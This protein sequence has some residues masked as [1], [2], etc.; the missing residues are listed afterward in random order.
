[1]SD[2]PTQHTAEPSDVH[3]TVESPSTASEAT[4]TGAA[5]SEPAA[6]QKVAEKPAENAP[7]E[8]TLAG[9]KLEDLPQISGTDPNIERF[10]ELSYTSP[11]SA[12]VASQ[13]LIDNFD[14][15]GLW[16]ASLVQPAHLAAELRQECSELSSLVIMQWVRQGE[17]HKL[18]VLSETLLAEPP[19][20]RTR[21]TARIMTVLA[22]LLGILRPTIA[23]RLMNTAT[24]YLSDLADG[25]LLRDARQ[26]VEAGRILERCQPEERVFWNRHL[27]EPGN[28]WDWDS[29][30]ARL[31]L[32]HL[33]GILPEDGGELQVFQAAVPGCW[34]DL[35]R[36]PR[37]ANDGKPPALMAPAA[38]QRKA[39]GFGPGLLLG[40]AAA[41]AIGWFALS[42]WPQLN[43][44]SASM[45]EELAA[46]VSA[47]KES[48]PPVEEDPS[49]SP[50]I[51]ESLRQ[52]QSVLK[53]TSPGP[54]EPSKST[55]ESSTTPAVEKAPA[56]VVT[57]AQSDQSKPELRA[58]ALARHAAANPE[59]KRLVSLVK[60]SS[61]RESADLI[62]GENSIAPRGSPTFQALIHWLILD[63]P[64]LADVRLAVTK[65]ALHSLPVE[66]T[67]GLF[68]LCF[69]P[70]S[71]N[72]LEIKQCANLILELPETSITGMQRVILNRIISMQ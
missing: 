72:E 35:W 31:A 54:V 20:R 71:P 52:L 64:Q 59:A 12:R 27:R 70:G 39:R 68:E 1:M 3:Q 41:V 65:L 10:M 4:G 37:Y 11:A 16:L 13:S 57:A 23:Q 43:Q 56:P 62:Q 61:Y 40:A 51:R 69:Y 50:P 58:A 66:D 9:L 63:P 42:Y 18:K 29:A 36:N 21:E 14:D 28:D 60:N 48:A 25:G 2:D 5:S 53:G 38:A 45:V 8:G 7:P 22:G 34:W 17:T 6:V 15:K 67:I 19:A 49:P 44:A 55:A 47:I 24:P 46:P 33:A 32:R 26:W 30:E